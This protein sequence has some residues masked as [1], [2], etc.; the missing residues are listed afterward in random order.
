MLAGYTE[1]ACTQ[2]RVDTNP[3]AISDWDFNLNTGTLSLYFTKPIL[4]SSVSLGALTVSEH[5]CLIFNDH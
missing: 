2:I 3:P 1:L 5:I 4:V